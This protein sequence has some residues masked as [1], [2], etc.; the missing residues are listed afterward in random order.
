MADS[1]DT[2]SAQEGIGLAR[3]IRV[4]LPPVGAA[5]VL[6]VTCVV[7]VAANPSYFLEYEELANATVARELLVGNRGL[8]LA[9]QHTPYCGGC[10]FVALIGWVF[11]EVAGL[12][13]LAWKAVPAAFAGAILL[14]CFALLRRTSGK[15]ASWAGAALILGAPAL[16]FRSMT[17]AWGN[18]F[19][20]VLFVLLQGLCVAAIL[21]PRNR[22]D[23]MLPWVAWG[24]WTGFGL[25]FCYGS[26]FAPP[27]LLLAVLLGVPMR[28]VVRRLP[29]AAIGLVAGIAPLLAYAAVDLGNPFLVLT[30]ADGESGASL[31]GRVSEATLARHAALLHLAP[32]RPPVAWLGVV[33]WGSLWLATV[34]GIALIVRRRTAHSPAAAVPPLLAAS[35][36][37]LFAASGFP[38][39]GGVLDSPLSL[40][41]L[42]P[43]MLLLLLAAA[44]GIGHLWD[45]GGV[46]RAVAIALLFATVLP[47]LWT[48]THWLSRPDPDAASPRAADIPPFNYRIFVLDIGRYP[49]DG[50]L[51]GVDTE[52]W[53]SRTNHLR[54][55]GYRRAQGL[56][57]DD[58]FDAGDAVKDLRALAGADAAASAAMMHGLG[59]GMAAA[60]VGR[61]GN[62]APLLP[63]ITAALTACTPEERRAMAVGLWTSLPDLVERSGHRADMRGLA[64]ALESPLA[65]ADCALCPL[66]GEAVAVVQ[67]PAPGNRLEDLVAGGGDLLRALPASRAALV[68]GVGAAHGREFGYRTTETKEMAADFQADDRTAFL[69]GFAAGRARIW[70]DEAAQGCPPEQVP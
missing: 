7:A 61:G 60:V 2:R 59:T 67:P 27:C 13:Y 32:G 5:L 29:I 26:V 46:L 37:A 17:M 10:T 39:E 9:A 23:R 44:A 3:L 8:L 16:V 70:A 36:M 15:A 19:E 58:S 68:E 62:A 34:A 48:R 49:A 24:F 38:T 55:V 31:L 22:G 21:G 52:D 56:V 14:T 51:I 50:V 69:R 66:L 20:V 33:T 40:R 30:T 28:T 64:A 42:A 47:G 63:P 53:I 4:W 12:T 6:A 1:R 25:W 45:R 18:H 65:A 35:A 43:S 41:Y 57:E 54:A 11:F